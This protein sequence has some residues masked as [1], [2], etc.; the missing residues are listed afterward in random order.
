MSDLG[1]GAPD[2][3][4]LDRWVSDDQAATVLG[5]PPERV[6]LLT[7]NPLNAV[8]GGI[9]RVTSAERT[10]VCKVLTDGRDH[11]GPAWWAA[12]ADPA[13]WNWWPR[14]ALVYANDLPGLFRP[15]GIDAPTPLLVDERSDGSTVLWLEWVEGTSGPGLGVEGLA[16][17][18]EALGRAQGRLADGRPDHAAWRGTPWLSRGFLSGYSDSKPVDEAL[19]DD[20]QAWAAPR[21]DQHLGELRDNLRRLHHE[22][23]SLYALAAACP[24]T[25]CHLDVWPANL[26]R[27]T[28]D[29]AFVLLDWAF[30]GDGALGEDVANLI[31]DAFFDLLYPHDLVDHL[32]AE[33]ETAYLAGLRAGGWQGDERWVALGIRSAAAKYHWLIERLLRDPDAQAVVYGGRSV[34][35]DDLYAARAAGLRLLCRWADEARA[36]ALDLGI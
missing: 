26:L 22:R 7:H 25:L 5:A 16:A 29:G 30:C 21:V 14:E 2:V 10:A 34:A 9:W 33:V 36:L 20:D 11:A 12:S 3:P 18:A 28:R 8:T 4:G 15:D 13:H 23:T 19:L 17:F 1:A 35:P 31:P 24:R 6:E 27:R 32:A